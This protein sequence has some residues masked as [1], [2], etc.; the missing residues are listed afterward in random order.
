M[1]YCFVQEDVSHRLVFVE[2]LMCGHNGCPNGLRAN[3]SKFGH[4]T[5]GYRPLLTVIQTL[6]SIILAIVTSVHGLKMASIT[7]PCYASLLNSA[8]SISHSGSPISCPRASFHKEGSPSTAS[9]SREQEWRRLHPK[10]CNPNDLLT[11]ASPRSC[12]P[13]PSLSTRAPG[14][15]PIRTLPPPSITGAPNSN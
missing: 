9:A 14:R 4:L 15:R 12:Q 1:K 6:S 10:P 8:S 2:I 13:P 7:S 5:L 3:A 11:V